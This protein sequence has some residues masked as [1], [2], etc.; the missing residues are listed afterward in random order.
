MLSAKVLRTIERYEML[1]PGERVLVALSG[2]ADSVALTEVLVQIAPGLGL[3]LVLAHLNHLLR[4]E[5]EADESF[6]REIAE[7]LRLP[8][9]CGRADVRAGAAKSRRSLE[10]EGRR[11][12]YQFLEQQAAREGCDRIAVGHTLDDQAETF[13]LR[14]LRGSGTRGLAG[15]HPVAGK[16][17]RPLIETR[18]SE[19]AAYLDQQN[20][21]FREDASNADL[22]YTRNR[23]R[24]SAMPG[25]LAEFNP[26]L[27]ETL[28]RSASILREDEE[29]MDIL[30]REA[31]AELGLESEGAIRLSV[32]GLLRCHRALRRR[33]V[34]RAIEGLRGGLENVGHVHVEDVLTL[35][36]AGKSGREVHLPGLVAERSFEELVFRVRPARSRQIRAER[37][38]NGFEYRLSIPARVR[39]PEGGGTLSV[40]MCPKGGE[41][42]DG[43]CRPSP[44]G[45][46]VIVG[47][48]EELPELTVRSPRRGDRFRPL[49]APGS[50]PLMRYLMERR[51]RREDR[52]SVPVVVAS[53][54]RYERNE[55][56][57]LW[58]V[59]H[60]VSE[61]SRLSRGGRRIELEWVT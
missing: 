32:P 45:S 31:F 47:V 24:H 49:G 30:V 48:E 20:I 1:R 23:I 11:A 44:A 33:L 41:A 17:I 13:L 16:R 42:F 10:D 18:R 43:D 27:A 12:R 35:L 52:R 21:P 53:G 37:G 50:K 40:R 46:A 9:V 26:R 2:G 6:C 4:I 7:R 51:V 15:V 14:L 34:R 8:I 25:L 3:S 57:I 58:V 36:D 60:G 38:Y 5:A 28:A 22:A 55:E 54:R 39:I 59:G 61:S 19:I 56:S 29:W